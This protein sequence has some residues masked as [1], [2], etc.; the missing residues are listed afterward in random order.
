MGQLNHREIIMTDTSKT[1]AEDTTTS[2]RPEPTHLELMFGKP[3]LMKGEGR[4][5]YEFLRSEVQRALAPTD[6]FGEL[7]V[8]EV[9][10]AIWEGQRFKRFATLL[11]DTGHVMA[12]EILLQSACW[13]SMFVKPGN[14]ARDYYRGDPK[15]RETAR[16]FVASLGI[17]EELIQAKALSVNAGEFSFADRL[18]DNRAIKLQGLLKEQERQKRRGEKAQRSADRE[19]GANDNSAAGAEPRAAATK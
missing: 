17:T 12:L 6:F 2:A 19:K 18:V 14:M 11:I 8:Q 1:S 3:R 4:A 15:E 13:H 10:D 5:P 7:R 9:T 16:K